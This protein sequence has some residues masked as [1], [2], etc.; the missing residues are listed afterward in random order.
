MKHLTKLDLMDVSFL[1]P[2]RIDSLSRLENLE[3]VVKYLNKYFNTHVLVMEVDEQ[4]KISEVIKENSDYTFRLSR[5]S[6]FRRTEINNTLIHSC[7]T[8]IAVLY[9]SDIVISP[10]QLFQAV[11]Q[12]RSKQHAFSLPYD[13]RF[14]Q[15]DYYNKRIF[16]KCIRI[17]FLSSGINQYS[18]DTN[19]SLGGCFMFDVLEYKKTGLENEHIEGWGHDDAERIKRI[20]KLDYVVY[21]PEGPLYHLW[22]ERGDNS[23]FFDEKR[24]RKSY[25]TY[26]RTCSIS[27]KE[28]EHDIKSWS[29]IQSDKIIKFDD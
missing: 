16:K 11:K 23:F 17:D 25:E 1:I 19:H 9:D 28:I 6:I 7:K 18:I 22:H 14:L 3:I 15:V 4:S 20:Q 29:W 8:P 12:I 2:V 13:G 5:T 21:R 10:F 27:R 26:F 24:E